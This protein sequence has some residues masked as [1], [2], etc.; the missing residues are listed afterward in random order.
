MDAEQ[1]KAGEARVKAFLI[2]PCFAA[3]L[4][5]PSGM[6]RDQFDAMVAE[7]CK[8]LAYMTELNLAALAETIS[9]NPVGKDANRW[10]IAAQVLGWAGK[11]QPPGDDASP[12]LRALFAHGIGQ[13]AI[14]QGW[15][16]E[17]LVWA[18]RERKFPG[19][20]VQ[21]KIREDAGRALRRAEDFALRRDRGDHLS[22]EEIRWLTMREAA[23]ARCRHIASLGRSGS[24]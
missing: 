11:I 4:L 19:G 5:R 9:V 21:K 14:A 24:S 6:A 15:G 12:F 17:L 10:P 1:Q 3:G 7:L 23:V 2:E 18:R 16:P 8:K 20:F 22:D 13:D